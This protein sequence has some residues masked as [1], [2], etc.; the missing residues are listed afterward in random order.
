MQLAVQVLALIGL[1]AGEQLLQRN[2]E[3]VQANT[4]HF[5]AFCKRHSEAFAFTA[6]RAGS[7]AFARLLTG[8]PVQAFCERLVA[9]CGEP[10][11]F[12]S[13]N[14]VTFESSYTLA[15]AGR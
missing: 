5:A 14:I 13:D 12:A 10:L 4:A 8:E 1:R 7:I 9:D 11:S 15:V 6:P 3:L 2:S